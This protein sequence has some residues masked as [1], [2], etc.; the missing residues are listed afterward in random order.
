MRL[1]LNISIGRL[2]WTVGAASWI[3]VVPVLG[4]LERSAEQIAIALKAAVVVGALG[5]AGGVQVAGAVSAPPRA[6]PPT[7]GV[8]ADAGPS[9]T[10]APGTA[11]GS[12]AP[13]PSP[14][15]SPDG[16]GGVG[17]DP[18]PTPVGDPSS[19]GPSASPD[20]SADPLGGSTDTVTEQVALPR[21]TS[22]FLHPAS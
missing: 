1:F 13:G 22:P 10:G 7:A 12:V 9:L 5:V 3:A 20:P 17:S 19:P 14:S 18:S 16:G 8:V 2:W 11:A 21:T 4:W 6:G 15:A